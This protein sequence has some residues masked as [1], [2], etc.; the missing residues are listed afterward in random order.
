[1]VPMAA[2]AQPWFPSPHRP[3]PT[4][5]QCCIPAMLCWNSILNGGILFP[6]LCTLGL[7][8]PAK[9]YNPLE[10]SQRRSGLRGFQGA[11]SRTT[12]DC[13]QDP[14]RSVCRYC[15]GRQLVWN[16]ALR[17]IKTLREAGLEVSLEEPQQGRA[18][19]PR[20][21]CEMTQRP[22]AVFWGGWLGVAIRKNGNG[23]SCAG[24]EGTLRLAMDHGHQEQFWCR[25]PSR[26][27]LNEIYFRL[28]L[29]R[30]YYLEASHNV[31]PFGKGKFL[32][33]CKGHWQD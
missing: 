8:S 29:D 20:M 31:F 21:L 33:F 16:T 11:C 17:V 27:W 30:L 32:C 19:A 7:W 26:W 28:I 14:L 18:V 5:P 4:L 1:M 15:V 12:G 24:R 3:G 25:G 22:K 9:G 6:H 10:G 23:S 13:L 2:V